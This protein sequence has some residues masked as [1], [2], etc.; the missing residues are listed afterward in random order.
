V[1][2]GI[3]CPGDEIGWGQCGGTFKWVGGPVVLRLSSEGLCSPPHATLD[4]FRGPIQFPSDPVSLLGRTR[5][6]HQAVN[7]TGRGRTTPQHLSTTESNLALCVSGSISLAHMKPQKKKQKTHKNT[8]PRTQEAR[9]SNFTSLCSS[10]VGGSD[11][12]ISPL[13]ERTLD[14]GPQRNPKTQKGAE[15]PVFRVRT[16]RYTQRNSF[17]WGNSTQLRRGDVRHRLDHG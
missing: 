2:G 7:S 3:C 16:N 12:M 15:N 13:C 8:W 17:T 4:I 10:G 14:E 6:L 11:A 9:V 5:Y 1:G